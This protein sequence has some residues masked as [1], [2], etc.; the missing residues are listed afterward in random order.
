MLWRKLYRDNRGV[1][2]VEFALIAPLMLVLYAGLTE[3][4]QAMIA[5]RRAG[6][7]ASTVGD[8]VA[9]AETVS[10]S[11]LT[12]IFKVGK[13]VMNPFDPSSLKQRVTSITADPNKVTK[14]DWSR[15]SGLSPFS[16]GATVTVPLA[17]EAGDSVVMA[18]TEYAYSSPIGYILPSALNFQEK[19]YLR[20]RRVD[21]VACSG[22]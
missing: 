21:K 4:C 15:G 11:E 8:L 1:S 18:E 16:A 19:F 13:T 5:E 10:T 7:V 6:H 3:V 14:V 22:C 20:P 2:A 12:D 9:Q 17:L